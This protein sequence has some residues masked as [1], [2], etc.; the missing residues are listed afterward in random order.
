MA[1]LNIT[2]RAVFELKQNAETLAV[3]N[4]VKNYGWQSGG[5]QIIWPV[6][7]EA[8]IRRISIMPRFDQA[9]NPGSPWEVNNRNKVGVWKWIFYA[10]LLDQSGKFIPSPSPKFV[11]DTFFCSNAL[12]SSIGIFFSSEK[13]FFEPVCMFASRFQPNQFYI[14]SSDFINVTPTSFGSLFVTVDYL[15]E[16][17]I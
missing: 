15:F 9:T 8:K 13:P 12:L 7:S 17:E 16:L 11:T 4:L 14:Y 6:D 1:F 5:A 2:S 3:G 10:R